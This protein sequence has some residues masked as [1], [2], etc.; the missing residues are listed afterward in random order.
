MILDDIISYKKAELIESKSKFPISALE[1]EI[2]NLKAPVNF[3]E[4]HSDNSGVK[5][6]AE[7]KKASPSKG[8]IREDFNHI[9]IARDY[10][11]S[12]AFALSVLTDKKFFMGD[13]AYLQ[14][15]RKVTS[16]PLLRKD[17]TVDAYQI[18][19]ARYYGADLVLL[20]AAALEPEIIKEF[21]LITDSL[22]MGAIVEVH[23]EK[24]LEVALK[25][26]CKI[27]GINNRD[28]KTF[29]VSLEVTKNLFRLIPKDKIVIAESGITSREDIEYL[30]GLGIDTFLIGECFMK[31][32]KPGEKLKT[33]LKNFDERF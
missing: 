7:I 27:I 18:Y 21:L 14:D 1:S 26:D 33:F 28:L 19:E 9:N 6:I 8:I 25:S 29:K 30:G 5:I 23:T 13:L 15:I 12:G 2:K 4:R 24:E 11:D 10:E 32:E 20:I 16:V 31:A 22:G 17:F 3:L